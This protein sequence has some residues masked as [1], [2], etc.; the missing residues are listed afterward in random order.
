MSL[1]DDMRAAVTGG[2]IDA[3]EAL[4]AEHP[5]A[6]RYLV[7]LM[8][9]PDDGI[10]RVGA[11]GIALAARHHPRVVKKIIERLLWAMNEESNTY[12]PAAPEVLLAIAEETP[13]LLVPVAA[14]LVRLSRDANL[15][16]GLGD[17][18]RRIGERCPGEV[19]QALTKSLNRRLKQGGC[20]CR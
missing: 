16:Q 2:D 19:G 7:G 4:A 9:R 14:D 13:E 8:Y 15:S 5:R 10:R 17:T 6:I 1:R 3:I 11:R 20:G 12:A 18:L